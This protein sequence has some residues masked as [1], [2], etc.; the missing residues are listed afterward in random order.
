MTTCTSTDIEALLGL[1][2][3]DVVEVAPLMSGITSE[4]TLL[5]VESKATDSVTFRVLFYGVSISKL[6]LR[7]TEKGVVWTSK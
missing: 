2:T 5:Q 6:V 1:S 3:G 7:K 4:L